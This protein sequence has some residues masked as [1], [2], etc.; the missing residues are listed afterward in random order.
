MSSPT[1]PRM[2]VSPPA[3]ALSE[4]D[5]ARALGISPRTLWELRTRG[6][7]PYRR[8][9]RRVLYSVDALRAW[10]TGSRPKGAG[11]DAD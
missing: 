3:L 9:G 2:E 8:I 10:L 5:A 7:V 1:T 4:R 6:E 11:D